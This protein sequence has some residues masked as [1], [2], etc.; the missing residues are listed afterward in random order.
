M[1]VSISSDDAAQIDQLYRWLQQD[2]GLTEHASL[3]GRSSD[4]S[5]MGWDLIEILFTNAVAVANLAVAYVAYRAA[6]PQS[7]PIVITR[8]DGRQLTIDGSPEAAAMAIC[9][10]LES[11]D[12]APEATDPSTTEPDA[13]DPDVTE[14]DGP[15]DGQP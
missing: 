6:R 1:R 12:E 13:T 9:R 8:Q 3:A 10:F 5:A 2:R 14:P 7:R 15:R 11:S 4:G